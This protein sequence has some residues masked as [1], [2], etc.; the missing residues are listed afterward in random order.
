[1]GK[2]D[3]VGLFQDGMHLAT[4]SELNAKR[5]KTCPPVAADPDPSGAEQ[6]LPSPW[7]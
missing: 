4:G 1:M 5:A 2:E 3:D 6:E 7:T